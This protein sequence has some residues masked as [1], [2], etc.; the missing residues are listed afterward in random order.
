MLENYLY[1]H[2]GTWQ[3]IPQWCNGFVALGQ[4]IA[5]RNSDDTRLVVGLA[6]PTRAYGAAFAAAG[7]V[8][9]RAELP[10]EQLDCTDHFLRLCNLP[11]QTP[12]IYREND[13]L[14]KGTIEG[15]EQHYG[16]AYIVVRVNRE[17]AKRKVPAFLATNIQ[18][19]GKRFAKLPKHQT[20]RVVLDDIPLL[21]ACKVNLAIRDFCLYPRLDATIIGNKKA[22]LDELNTPLA[23]RTVDDEFCRGTLQDILRLKERVTD[24]LG[25]RTSL[26]SEQGG[27]VKPDANETPR[28]VIFDGAAGFLKWRTM[29]RESDWIVMLDKTETRF[30]EAVV[31]LNQE[32]VSDRLDSSALQFPDMPIAVDMLAYEEKRR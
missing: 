21:R 8:L 2:G 31:T 24:G 10:V 14:L 25:Y 9:A 16:S 23:A 3:R 27:N 7:Y 28:L 5:R 1:E 26:R 15:Y 11:P 18:I 29:W 17:H 13:R 12:V 30:E 4:T 19:S 6:V 32:Y 20:G 22:L